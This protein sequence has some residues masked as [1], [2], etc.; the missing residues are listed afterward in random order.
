MTTLSHVTGGYTYIDPYGVALG[1]E[2]VFTKL[3]AA[4]RHYESAG[5]GK[6]YVRR[7]VR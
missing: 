5:L 3:E 7:L 2:V 1:Y 4:S 6:D